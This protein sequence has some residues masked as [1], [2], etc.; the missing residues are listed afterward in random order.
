MI[1]NGVLRDVVHI[2]PKV[3]LLPKFHYVS[4]YT[5]YFNFIY[6]SKEST[7]YSRPIFTK[8]TIDQ[9][10]Y[11]KISYCQFHPKRILNVERRHR[12]D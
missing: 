11:V 10:H 7:K 4:R 8:L 3:L 5:S 2:L 9:P 12:K 1:A 6:A